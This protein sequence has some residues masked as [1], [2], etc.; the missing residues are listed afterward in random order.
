MVGGCGWGGW[1][2]GVGWVLGGVC[3][4]CGVGVGWVWVG[5]VLTLLILDALRLGV[6]MQEQDSPLDSVSGAASSAREQEAA[7]EVKR[8]GNLRRES[9]GFLHRQLW[10]PISETPAGKNDIS[11]SWV[12]ISFHC[13]LWYLVADH[14]IH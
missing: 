14:G 12:T 5:W 8:I 9:Y 13:V 10:V 4:V 1:V 2:G 6:R 3:V 11:N 7:I